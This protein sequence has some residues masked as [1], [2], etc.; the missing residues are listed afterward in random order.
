MNS[1]V[2]FALQNAKVWSKYTKDISIYIEK[3]INF[4][5]ENSKNLL[6]LAQTM[7]P[8]LSDN[9]PLQQL[10]LNMLD[11]DIKNHKAY[12]ANCSLLLGHKFLEPLTILRNENEKCRKAC[13]NQWNREFKKL[14][15]SVNNLKKA[16]STYIAKKIE[17]ERAK[18]ALKMVLET[19][20]ITSSYN[21]SSNLNQSTNQP[22]FMQS[23][24]LSQQ[25][26][27]IQ[28]ESTSEQIKLDKK[29]KYEED[30]AQ[31][32]LDAENVYRQA[33][34]DANERYYLIKMRLKFKKSK[35]NY[36]LFLF[37]YF[38]YRARTCENIK[39]TILNRIKDLDYK[40]DL[41]LTSVTG[42]H[43]NS[44]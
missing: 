26:N 11:L 6:K 1:A 10:Y 32:T 38:E 16:R 18:Q 13:K 24:N 36:L 34:I 31:K 27:H 39:K 28:M 21:L 35:P 4:Q 22:S 14:Q 37:A 2:E 3:R 42:R 41:T 5:M 44:C 15:D 30:A 19:G 29:R 20:S 43:T 17:L 7:K 8:I 40:S 25:L 9:L 12:F 33:V 23:S